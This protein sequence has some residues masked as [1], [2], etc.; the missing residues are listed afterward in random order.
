MANTGVNTE[1]SQFVITHQPLPQLDGQF[2]AFGRVIDGF[3][4]ILKFLAIDPR[5][6]VPE[7]GGAARQ[8]VRVIKAEVVR[9]RDHEY[10]PEKT[11][12]GMADVL[13]GTGIPEGSD[14]TFTPRSAS[15]DNS[16]IDGGSLFSPSNP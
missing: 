1:G 11:K 16:P 8:P 3:D 12:P 10:N 7:D 5:N 14:S 9:K 2:T 13:G 15:Q 6:P 4:T